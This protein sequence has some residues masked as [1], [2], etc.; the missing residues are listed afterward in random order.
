MRATNHRPAIYIILSLTAILASAACGSGDPTGTDLAPSLPSLTGVGFGSGNIGGSDSTVTTTAGSE[1][2]T[3][4][5]SGSTATQR[6]GV[7]FG[8]G[9]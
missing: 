1:N 2:T 6:G 3:A 5:D 7:T 4:A 9:N 8:S